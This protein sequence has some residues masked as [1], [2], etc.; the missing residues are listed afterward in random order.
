MIRNGKTVAAAVLALALAATPAPA[1]D[2]ELPRGKAVV[3]QLEEVNQHLQ[4]LRKEVGDLRQDLLTTA[5][6]AQRSRADLKELDERLRS[7]DA[8]VR[9]Q[10][11]LATQRPSLPPDLDERLRSLEALLHRQSELVT[12]QRFSL[13]PDLDERLRSLEALVRRQSELVTTQR[14]SY[15]PDAPLRDRLAPTGAI[16]LQNRSGAGATVFVN[17]QANYLAPFETRTL[18]GQ[19]A[20]SFTYE[21]L[22]DGFG[23]I[24]PR[25][26]RDLRAGEVFTIHVNPGLSVLLP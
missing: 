1:E 22:A 16:R 26:V 18:A 15:T 3:K 17:G 20:G 5:T 2:P 10:G 7:L 25:V 14:F 13:P 24:Q 8:L 4:A 11:E 6:T 19:P 9:R 23:T 12:T 21:V